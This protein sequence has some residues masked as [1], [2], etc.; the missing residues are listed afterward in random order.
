MRLAESTRQRLRSDTAAGRTGTVLGVRLISGGSPRYR[1]YE[2][3][4]A[5][6]ESVNT[7][8]ITVIYRPEA[9]AFYKSRGFGAFLFLWK[10]VF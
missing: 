10:E 3:F 1:A 6:T 4:S 8:G 9:M 2:A 5:Y 7:G